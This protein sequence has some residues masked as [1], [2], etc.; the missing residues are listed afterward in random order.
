MNEY[1]LDREHLHKLL[2]GERAVD[3]DY[4]WSRHGHFDEES[5]VLVYERDHVPSGNR[6][7]FVLDRYDTEKV[8]WAEVAKVPQISY[9]WIR[10]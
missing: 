8:V 3:G 9:R 10:V 1:V 5:A 6:R 2:G 7:Y 4:I